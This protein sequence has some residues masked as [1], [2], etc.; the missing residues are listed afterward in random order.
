MNAVF[1]FIRGAAPWLTMGIVIAIFTARGALP[2]Q[3]V[4]ALQGAADAGA[5]GNST[6]VITGI[7]LILASM[8][9]RYGAQ[10][11]QKPQIAEQ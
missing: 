7:V 9:F 2:L 1:D 3:A 11:E 10:L 8:I 5:I 4:A 6:E